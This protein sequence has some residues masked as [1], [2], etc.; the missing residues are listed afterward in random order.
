MP[1]TQ[2][3]PDANRKEVT[4]AIMAPEV[5]LERNIRRFVKPQGG[6]RKDLPESDQV[7]ALALLKKAGRKVEDGWDMGIMVPGFTNITAQAPK[8]P[9]QALRDKTIIDL[10]D[11]NKKLLARLDRLENADPLASMT[12]PKLRAYASDAQ[13]DVGNLTRKL[14]ILEFIRDAE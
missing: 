9:P 12:I 4:K 2:D 7:E 6:F 14:D 1:R 5:Q 10:M 11:A 13:I 8:A 3:I